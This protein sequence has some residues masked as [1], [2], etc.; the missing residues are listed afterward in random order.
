MEGMGEEPYAPLLLLLG[1]TLDHVLSYTLPDDECQTLEHLGVLCGVCRGFRS[2]ARRAAPARLYLHEFKGYPA[3]SRRSAS[4]DKRAR[5]LRT[6][7]RHGWMRQNLEEFHVNWSSVLEKNYTICHTIRGLL[8]D[9]L[10]L[11][12]GFPN[13]T[14]LDIN[15]QCDHFCGYQGVDGALLQQ[16]P[17]AML[18]L[19]RLCL[20]SCFPFGEDN[21]EEQENEI[22]PEQ[23]TNFF[24][25]LNRPLQSLSLGLV[26][27][28]DEHVE[29][30]MP[31][32]GRDLNKLELMGCCTCDHEEEEEY[33][34]GDDSAIAVANSCKNLATLAFAESDITTSAL[35]SVLSANAGI[36][37]LDLSSNKRLGSDTVEVIAQYLPQLTELRNY[38]PSKD[39]DWLSNTALKSLCDLLAG[40]NGGDMPLS[41]LGLHNNVSRISQGILYAIRKGLK[42]IEIDE[43]YLR[44]EIDNSGAA[45]E[46][47]HPTYVYHIDG[48]QMNYH[49]G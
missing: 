17:S 4:G 33:R 3:L 5:V 47:R 43:E 48:S 8:R 44:D 32:V 12:G 36:R 31:V 42:V 14:W 24:R 39:A 16:M 28:A 18:S 9:L 6:L 25:K 20:V 49:I 26:R 10:S 35:R 34:L 23:W 27:M 30:F 19:E 7:L 41:L 46:I 38:W 13:L 45:V 1:E 11:P 40:N 15:L 29:A 37:K 21:E 2:S 22:T